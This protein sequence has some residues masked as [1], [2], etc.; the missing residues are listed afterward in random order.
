MRFHG[1]INAQIILYYMCIAEFSNLLI[2]K[3][4]DFLNEL[5]VDYQVSCD[6]PNA[7]LLFFIQPFGIMSYG[8]KHS[9]ITDI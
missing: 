8:I 5:S 4:R 2:T 9:R 1:Q 6:E 3:T 7:S